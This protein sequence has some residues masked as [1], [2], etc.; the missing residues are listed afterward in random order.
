VK[1]LIAIIKS[2]LE[3]LDIRRRWFVIV[4][5]FALVLLVVLGFEHFAG[6]YYY[7]SLEKKVELLKELHSLAKDDIAQD[8]DLHPVY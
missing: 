5:L 6:Y 7:R 1:D 3:D 8:Q 2:L 4:S